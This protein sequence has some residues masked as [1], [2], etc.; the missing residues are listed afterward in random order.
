MKSKKHILIVDDVAENIQVAMNILKEGNYEFSFAEDGQTALNILNQE[1]IDFDL[2]LLDIMMPGES[3]FEICKKIKNNPRIKD[4]PVIFLTARVDLESIERGFAVGGVDYITKPFHAVELLAR[5]RNHIQLYRAKSFLKQQNI[6]LEQ[7]SKYEQYRLTTELEKTQL[8][9][10]FILTELMEGTSDETGKHIRRVAEYS[11]LFA[12]L[13]PSLS[14]DDAYVLFHASPMHD[15]GKITIPPEILHKP[16]KYSDE[17]F[18]IMKM[19]TT[20]A[21]KL[22]NFSERKVI[23]SA[24]IIAHEH[25]EKWDGTGY[26]RNLKGHDIHIYGRIVAIADVLDALTHERC[27]KN[28]WRFNKA[29][30]YIQQHKG[31]HF[32]PELVDILMENIKEFKEICV[33]T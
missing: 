19:H 3:G 30:E 1:S 4:L 13:H 20:N 10:I 22:L 12:Y 23:R 29:I 26:P 28:A 32:D 21:F 6:D 9:T 33:L 7:K 25:H 17:E 14:N 11:S 27:Y 15:I 8:D 5:V 2:I 31:S 18:E 16:G 24:A